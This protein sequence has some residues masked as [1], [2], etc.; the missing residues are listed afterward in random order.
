MQIRVNLR[1]RMDISPE[2]EDTNKRPEIAIWPVVSATK[3]TILFEL[4]TPW[5]EIIGD[6]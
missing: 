6:V 2:I 1:Q 3:Q 4:M 5:E